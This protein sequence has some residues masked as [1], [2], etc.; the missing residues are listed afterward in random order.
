[1][2][3]RLFTPRLRVKS[4]E[5][6][7]VWLLDKCIAYA[8]AHRHPKQVERT[9]WQ[10]FEEERGSLVHYVGPFDG[11]DCVPASVPKTCSLPSALACRCAF[12]FP[13]D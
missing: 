2:R 13:T 11:F 8:K 1:M 5:E 4:L 12:P 10:M 3:E 9:I 6:L 7:N